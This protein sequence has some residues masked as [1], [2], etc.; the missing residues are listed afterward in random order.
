MAIGPVAALVL[1]PGPTSSIALPA[2]G[3]L[4]AVFDPA[5]G[6]SGD[7]QALDSLAAPWAAVL[8]PDGG[9]LVA[10]ISVNALG[11]L[12][13]FHER[14]SDALHGLDESA[15][16]L[17]PG[18]WEARRR[19]VR[20]HGLAVSLSTWEPLARRAERFGVALPAALA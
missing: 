16:R 8:A 1:G 7:A 12:S 11:T 2:P 9:W 3:G 20:E 4:P 18:P 14:V 15:G 6:T 17:L 19:G 5:L 13:T 10:A